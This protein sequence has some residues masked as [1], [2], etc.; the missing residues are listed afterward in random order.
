MAGK[1]AA[2]KRPRPEGFLVQKILSGGIEV[3]LGLRRDP[4]LGPLGLLGAGGVFAELA[5]DSAIRLLPVTETDA[6]EM[7]SEL[8][9]SRILNGYRG[10]TQYDEIGRAHV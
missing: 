10:G 7:V 9:L 1:L 4:Q 3:I 6:R 5:D 2:Q 8:R